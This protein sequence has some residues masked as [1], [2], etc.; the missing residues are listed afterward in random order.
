ML[1]V[2]FNYTCSSSFKLNSCALK[3]KKNIFFL[4]NNVKSQIFVDDFFLNIFLLCYAFKKETFFFFK[5]KTITFY[6]KKKKKSAFVITRGPNRHKLSKDTLTVVNNKFNVT[7]RL[8]TSLPLNYYTL[9]KVVNLIYSTT[10]IFDTV[11]VKCIRL[12]IKL[13]FCESFFFKLI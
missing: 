10:T 2:D 3:K 9:K 1:P 11:L 12:N 4:K 5:L 7:L 8:L 13:Q 6:F